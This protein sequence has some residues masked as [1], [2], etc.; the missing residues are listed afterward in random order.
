MVS[1]LA[2]VL[3]YYGP[4]TMMHRSIVAP[5]AILRDNFW[6]AVH[7]ATIMGSYA[8]AAIALVLGDFALGWYIFGS[9]RGAG[10][11]EPEVRGQ[12]E[13]ASGG[14]ASSGGNPP[15]GI[16]NP[17]AANGPSPVPEA[18]PV[19]NSALS[20]TIVPWKGTVPFLLTQ[21]SGQSPEACHVLAGFAYTAIQITVF[22]LAAGTIL[23]AVW[24]DNAW[25]HFWGWDS[26][27]V[28]ALISL[29]VYVLLL[30]VRRAGGPAISACA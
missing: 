28:W 26:K 24:A 12:G 30:H 13:A 1:L 23:G 20:E 27:E 2:M 21:K 11:Q 18:G 17:R 22:L 9:Y 10:A 25:G 7:V 6:L 8:S 4:T 29:L 14:L 16:S 3:A 15:S 5:M 19:R